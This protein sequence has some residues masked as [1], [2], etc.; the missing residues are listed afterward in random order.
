[1]VFSVWFLVVGSLIISA[2][3][4]APAARH[5]WNPHGL[6]GGAFGSAA[7]SEAVQEGHSGHKCLS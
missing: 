3:A 1:L 2:S 7:A 4:G 5:P 6:F